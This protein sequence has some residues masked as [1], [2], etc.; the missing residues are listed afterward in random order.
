M[1]EVSGLAGT[2]SG[3]G[4]PPPQSPLE[5][6]A[7]QLLQAKKLQQ[8]SAEATLQSAMKIAQY[9]PQAAEQLAGP[10][11]QTIKKTT[12]KSPTEHLFQSIYEQTQA[13]NKQKSDQAAADLAQTQQATK[14]SASQQGEA[15]VNTQF[16]TLRNQAETATQAAE[17][18][19]TANEYPDSDE[20]DQARKQ[21]ARFVA[22]HRNL[23]EAEATDLGMTKSEYKDAMQLKKDAVVQSRISVAE[24]MSNLQIPAPTKTNPNAT[25]ALTPEEVNGIANGKI[26]AN[27]TTNA[28][29]RNKIMEAT[30]QTAANAEMMNAKAN[31][32][33]TDEEIE[34]IASVKLK[35]L[36]QADALQRKGISVGLDDL[37]KVADT[38]QKMKASG[39]K[40]PTELEDRMH[41][42]IA[43]EM[44]GTPDVQDEMFGI[45]KK[46]GWSFPQSPTDTP[47]V[48]N[49]K[50][51]P[52]QDNSSLGTKAGE[53]LR[54]LPTAAEVAKLRAQGKI[55]GAGLEGA[56]ELEDFATALAGNK[57]GP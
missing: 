46:N 29:V 2:I 30:S 11:L 7:M 15:D 5:G 12:G 22:I 8:E 38:M 55:I 10:A 54:N 18:R 48:V 47:P 32:A 37:L 56:Q 33:K 9:D 41:D 35:N 40:V 31:K 16:G 43:K 24:A 34:E 52:P 19:I 27:L 13:A 39:D 25:R 53:G 20:G 17:S 4:T 28:A 42:L 26:P 51:P 23:S 49:Q 44:G 57:K 50:A 36:A 6:F 21:D 45:L 14:T 3:P 1:P